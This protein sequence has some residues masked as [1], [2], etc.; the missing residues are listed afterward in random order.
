MNPQEVT[1]GLNTWSIVFKNIDSEEWGL[2]DPNEQT[3][4]ID[5][6]MTIDAQRSTLLHE[7]LHALW[8]TFGWPAKGKIDEEE[9]ISFMEMPLLMFIRD[10]PHIVRW[11]ENS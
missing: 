5:T 9:V 1:I 7:C 6:K 3:I 4:Y 10:N 11:F 8:V 2:C